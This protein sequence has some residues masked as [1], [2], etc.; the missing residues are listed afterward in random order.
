M[1][2]AAAFA[3]TQLIPQRICDSVPVAF[4][5]EHLDRVELRA[6]ARRRRRRRRCCAPRR[7]RRRACRGRCRPPRAS[8]LDA[9]RPAHG[10]RGRALARSIAGVEHGD[11]DA[12]R[13]VRLGADHAADAADAGR[14]VSPAASGARPAALNVMSGWTNATPAAAPSFGRLVGGQVRGE[15]VERAR[16]P[17]LRGEA[18]AALSASIRAPTSVTASSKH[19]DVRARRRRSPPRRPD[20]KGDASAAQTMRTGSPPHAAVT[21]RSQP[22]RLPAPGSA[23]G[24]RR[25]APGAPW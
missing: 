19:D 20:R 2:S 12:A 21:F 4:G 9:V 8:R 22:G 11:A 14:T 18:E 6:R 5:A 23:A 1:L 17:E 15:A 24:T 16:V 7:C 25:P 13:G 10:R 3:V